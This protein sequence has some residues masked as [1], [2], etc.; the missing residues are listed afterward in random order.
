MSY[1]I[2]ATSGFTS[3]DYKLPINYREEWESLFLPDNEHVNIKLGVREIKNAFVNHFGLVVK[4]GL[5]VKGCAPNIGFGSY[6]HTKYYSHWKKAIEQSVVSKFG[7]SIPYISLDS[8]QKYLLIHS[9]WFSYYFWL[10]ECLP[11]LLSVEEHFEDL[12]LLYP[13]DW[14]NKPFVN[15]SLAM[16]PQLKRKVI[17]KDV[18]LRV[19]NLVMPEVKPWTPMFIPEHIKRVREFLFSALDSK[20]HVYNSSG[21]KVYL[22]RSNAVRRKFDKEDRIEVILRDKG[23]KAVQME[24][25]SFFD[26]VSLMRQTKYMTGLTGAGHINIMF[27][28]PGGG[29]LDLT[30]IKYLNREQYKFHFYK[31]CN[32]VNIPYGVSFFEHENKEGLDHY[33]NQNLILNEDLLTKDIN[34]LLQN[35]VG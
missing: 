30:N 19:K 9:P 26:Q 31:L 13:E 17:P 7:S 32:I 2:K 1:F 28:K 12:V 15:E 22:S 25:L 24:N 18:H 11:R 5:L 14:S 10:T 3:I 33:S 16:F 23:F 29:F 4:N 35:D 8:N 6:D 20:E 34:K 21:D 27:M